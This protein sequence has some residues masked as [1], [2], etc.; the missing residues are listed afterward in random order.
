VVVD[1]EP[2]QVGIDPYN[3]LI[4]RTPKDNVRDVK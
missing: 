4:D 2:T 1:E 3:K